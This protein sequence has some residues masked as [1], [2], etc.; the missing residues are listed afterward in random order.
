MEFEASGGL[1][2]CRVEKYASPRRIRPETVGKRSFATVIV[3]AQSADNPS[4][5]TVHADVDPPAESR[6]ASLRR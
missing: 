3:F 5:W 1:E 2:T 6:H 4:V